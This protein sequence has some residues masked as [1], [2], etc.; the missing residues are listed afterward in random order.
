[1]GRPVAFWRVRA[2]ST[3]RDSWRSGYR[4]QRQGSLLRGGDVRALAASS[5][6]VLVVATAMCG[7]VQ[8]KTFQVYTCRDAAE[9]PLGRTIGWPGVVSGWDFGAPLY[10]AV[11]LTDDCDV[12]GGGFGFQTRF[13]TMAAG[14]SIGMRWDGGRRNEARG[15][16]GAV[17]H[18]GRSHAGPRA[19][20]SPAGSGHRPT[21]AVRAEQSGVGRLRSR[22]SATVRGG[23]RTGVLVRDPVHLPRS[24]PCGI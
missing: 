23:C 2:P 22:R 14:E 4:S 16:L 21:A 24:M 1:M 11:P 18:V 7:T 17:G 15:R 12:A 13:G 5:L 9:R 8:A 20:H 6:A 10:V 19:G 3:G